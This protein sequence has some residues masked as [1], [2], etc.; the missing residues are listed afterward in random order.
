MN[1][2]S[3]AVVISAFF[4]LWWAVAAVSLVLAARPGSGG[5]RL[6][7]RW[8]ALSRTASLA[9]LVPI[10]LVAVTWTAVPVA[11]WYLL[12]ALTAAAVA[13]VVLRL[14]G[15]PARGQDAGAPGRRAS[16]I[17]NTALAAALVCALALFLP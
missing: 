6:A 10:C 1:T 4:C 17:G 2:E 8:D 13:L 12:T 7:D 15:L 3:V 9:F 5:R 11:L 14:P 16:A